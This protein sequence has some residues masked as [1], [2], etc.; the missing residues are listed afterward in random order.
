MD[1]ERSDGGGEGGEPEVV[2]EF[3]CAGMLRGSLTS[4]HSTVERIFGVMFDIGVADLSHANNGQIWLKL[5]GQS[6]NVKAAKVSPC[7]KY[8]SPDCEPVCKP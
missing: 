2:D 5:Q 8:I 3:A 7:L 1:A 4:L 6:N